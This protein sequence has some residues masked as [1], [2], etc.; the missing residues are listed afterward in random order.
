LLLPDTSALAG[1][2]HVDTLVSLPSYAAHAFSN[3][4]A[5]DVRVSSPVTD[6]SGSIAARVALS[7]HGNPVGAVVVVGDAVDIDIR[8]VDALVASTVG[9]ARTAC[10]RVSSTVA[11]ADSDSIAA[12]V[13]LSS[14]IST[15]SA[16]VSSPVTDASGSIAARVTLSSRV[17]TVGALVAAAASDAVDIDIRPVDALVTS[18]VD[19]ARTV[20]APTRAVDVDTLPS[21]TTST[22]HD[23]AGAPATVTTVLTATSSLRGAIATLPPRSSTSSVADTPPSRVSPSHDAPSMIDALP[24]RVAS[25]TA[26]RPS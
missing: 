26:G 16:L 20:G 9:G 6:A 8:P 1:G 4:N 25:G 3:A 11:A 21:C 5:V 10:V 19:G 23:A 13:T 22:H 14:H 17:N 18:T 2:R 7:S 15:V 24:P 12:R